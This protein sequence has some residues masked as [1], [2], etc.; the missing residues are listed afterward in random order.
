ML[1]RFESVGTNHQKMYAK[2]ARYFKFYIQ[3]EIYSETIKPRTTTR[4]P[5]VGT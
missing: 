2:L 4:S 3:S 5:K 1:R